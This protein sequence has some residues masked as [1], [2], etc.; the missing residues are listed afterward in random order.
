MN[1]R[2]LTLMFPSNPLK[3]R[4][5]DPDYAE[6][7]QVAGDFTHVRVFDLDLLLGEGKLKLNKKFPSSTIVIYRGWMLTP[8]NYAL[9]QTLVESANASLLTNKEA[10]QMT[11]LLPNWAHHAN[12]L[13]SAWTT[14]LTDNALIKL[15]D[16]FN[17]PVTVKDFVKSRKHEWY[18][19][20]YIPNPQNHYQAL[21]IIHN[22]IQRQAENLVGG[23]V[24]REFVPFVQTGVH[25]KN[26]TPIYEEY[27]VFYW[28]SEPFAMIDY[29]HHNF[30]SLG[31]GDLIF[32]RKSGQRIRSPFFTIDFAR[33]TD[34]TLIIVEIGDGQV[35]GLQDYDT[36]KFYHQWF[37]RIGLEQGDRLK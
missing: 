3:P 27:R 12:T 34:G 10:Y 21:A 11:H 8:E 5:P 16:Q 30:D 26:E 28:H 4:E 20:F 17:G 6:E 31:D 29:W 25:L 9:L 35:S 7:Y 14:D 22:F 23:I 32:V 18:S 1:P 2:N 36:R 13:K 24:I 37:Q 15:L 33:K 19:A